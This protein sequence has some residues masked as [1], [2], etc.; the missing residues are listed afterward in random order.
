MCV[1]V[2]HPNVVK[3][4]EMYETQKRLYLVMELLTGGELFDRIVAKGQFSE[5]DASI[6][7]QRVASALQYLHKQGIVHR[8]LKVC[9]A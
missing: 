8:D 2:A 4:Y 1:Q 6:V 5:Q 9:H 3:L 7:V